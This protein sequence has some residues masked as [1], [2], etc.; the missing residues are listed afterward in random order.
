MEINL[1]KSIKRKVKKGSMAYDNN[2]LIRHEL[3]N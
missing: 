1:Y 2:Y 3:T